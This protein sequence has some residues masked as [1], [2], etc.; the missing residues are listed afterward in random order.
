[1]PSSFSRSPSSILSTG[2]PV[3]RDTTCATW[4]AVTA[5]SDE[6]VPALGFDLGELAL[7]IRDHAIGQFAR[8][9][10]LAPALRLNEFVSGSLELLLQLLRR[11]ELILLGAPAHGQGVRLLLQA[12][13][14]AFEL[15]EPIL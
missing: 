11:A 14:F 13:E 1:M 8:A 12:V 6:P 7:E 5:S 9:L 2:T 15:R 10:I 3:Q 4:S